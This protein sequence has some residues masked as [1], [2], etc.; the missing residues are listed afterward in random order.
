M[1]LRRIWKYE[2]KDHLVTMQK[3]AVILSAGIDPKGEL[4]LWALVDPEA[5]KVERRIAIRETGGVVGDAVDGH[6]FI[7]TVKNGSY[8]WHL[9]D[10][11]EE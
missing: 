6:R 9:F 1:S 3:G 10:V 8:M 2:V 5:P 7:G 4:C 11:G